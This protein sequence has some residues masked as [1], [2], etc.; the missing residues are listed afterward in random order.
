M[1]ALVYTYIEGRGVWIH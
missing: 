1:A